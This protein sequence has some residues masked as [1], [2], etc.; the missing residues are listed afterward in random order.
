MGQC[1][2]PI[3]II[4]N[5]VFGTAARRPADR[6]QAGNVR[7]NVARV[8]KTVLMIGFWLKGLA[9][10]F[11]RDP[12]HFQNGVGLTAPHIEDLPHRFRMLQHQQ[13]GGDDIDNV[14]VIA[15]LQAILKNRWLLF[16]GVRKAKNA[17]G[18]RIGIGKRLARPLHDRIAQGHRGNLIAPPQ[19]E[20]D[21]LLHIFG[22]G[23]LILRIDARF[24]GRLE[25]K[26]FLA[27]GAEQV[28]LTLRQLRLGA[29]VGILHAVRGAAIPA[30]AINGLRRGH[31]DTL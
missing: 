7:N 12:G 2:Q 31:N 22:Q 21:A 25:L 26:R 17:A 10:L 29:D 9:R 18:P 14:D 11:G 15:P 20:R 3:E 1:R 27:V 30:F 6:A 19:I 8:A 16:L 23:I 24:V 5:T 4:P 13:V 28:P